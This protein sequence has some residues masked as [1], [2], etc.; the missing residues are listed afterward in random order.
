[1]TFTDLTTGEPTSWNGASTGPVWCFV[2]GTSATSQNPQVQFTVGGLYT[3]TLVASN[4]H[5]TNTMIKTGYIR[6][7]ISGLWTGN[8]SSNWNTM[9][10]WDNWGVARQQHRCGHPAVGAQL[11]GI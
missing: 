9:T 3:V 8:T 6:A 1:V 11:A 4:S 10:N 7:G 5:L 2:N